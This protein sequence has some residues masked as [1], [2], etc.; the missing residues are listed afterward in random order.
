[1]A[2]RRGPGR[3]G[4]LRAQVREVL[5]DAYAIAERLGAVPLVSRLDDVA[6]AA[7]V[8]LDAVP[9]LDTARRTGSPL[10][11]REHQVLDLVIAGR[12]NAEIAATLFISEKTA[13]TRVQHP[14]EDGLPEP[15]RGSCLG[16]A[17]R[18]SW[19]SVAGNAEVPSRI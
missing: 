3:Q 4:A 1:M 12:T 8:R 15:D 7:H 6:R 11:E 13:D 5:R 19:V 16:A 17:A 9:T 18:E 2:P 14:A 10:S